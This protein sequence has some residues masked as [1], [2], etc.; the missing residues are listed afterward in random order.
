M[1]NLRFRWRSVAKHSFA[2]LPVAL[3]CSL[4]AAACGGDALGPEGEAPDQLLFLSTRDGATDQLGRP[5]FDIYRVNADGTGVRNLTRN[6]AWLYTTL[7]VSPDGN[8][9]IFG[10][11]H[12]PGCDLWVMATDGTDLRRITNRDGGN[13]ER[14]NALPAWSPDGSR[15][16]FVSNR[17]N[18][19]AGMYSGLYDVYVMNA[20]GSNPRNVSSSLGAAMG[21]FVAMVG[22]TPDGRIMFEAFDMVGGVFHR[23]VHVVNADGTGLRP[24]LN[25]PGD[26]SPRWSPDGSRVA[27]LSNR[28]GRAKLYVMSGD[29]SGVRSLSDD[30]GEDALVWRH[31]QIEP[32]L[33]DPW[34]PDGHTIAFH[35]DRDG[36]MAIYLVN[37]DGTGQRRLTDPDLAARFNGWS[38]QGDRIVFTSARIPNDVYVINADGTGLRNVT[39]SGA[40]DSDALWLRRR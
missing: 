5:M 38:P 32:S 20:D 10:S 11:S 31:S 21:M 25:R 35:N 23:R 34:S 7:G 17:D 22:W 18:R 8:R 15:I 9:I 37:A 1:S 2:M 24:L 4:V 27:F 13:A 30:P 14:C 6:P 16:A 26:H 29:G 19:T 3:F 12:A 40:D 33:Y 36:L 28:G 39:S